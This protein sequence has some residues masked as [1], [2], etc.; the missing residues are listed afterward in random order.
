VTPERTEAARRDLLP[1]L[2]LARELAALGSDVAQSYFRRDPDTKR[3][4]DGTWATEADLEAEARIRAR[5]AEARP[6]H[7]V[8]GEEEG[9]S[10]SVGGRAR[11]GAPTWIVD[12]IDGTNNFM[13]GI[14]VWATLVGL[15][16]DDETVVGVC[17][18]PALRETYDA[19]L[20]GGARFNGDPIRVD[21]ISALER[22]TVC[23]PGSESFLRSSLGEFHA[24][25]VSRC[26]RSRGFGDFWG[27]VLVAR[28][29]AHVMV[30]PELNP[31]DVAPLEPIVSEAGGRVT[32][33]SGRPWQ[34]GPCLTTN[35][36]LHAE[37]LA[38]AA[39]AAS[40]R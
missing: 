3:K 5:I 23:L 32:D 38:L 24:A 26:Y 11:P 17:H 10:A 29:A 27:H 6:D 16:V 31:W 34:K 25:L 13:A 18:A 7:N 1:D 37:V 28:G 35:G 14:P 30:E 19:C 33:L 36:A 20:G 15:R 12:P 9:L 39:P 40:G 4:P 22:A 2:E 21:A 8:L